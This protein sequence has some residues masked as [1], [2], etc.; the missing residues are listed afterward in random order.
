MTSIT[1]LW[2]IQNS[3]NLVNNEIKSNAEFNPQVAAL[4][5][6][7][8]F[9][10]GKM[11]IEAYPLTQ[12]QSGQPRNYDD[13]IAETEFR[14]ERENVMEQQNSLDSKPQA[15]VGFKLDFDIKEKLMKYMNALINDLDKAVQGELDELTLNKL[16][17]Q[18]TTFSF[19]YNENVSDIS[20][21]AEF[22]PNFHAQV[23]KIERLFLKIRKELFDYYQVG[24]DYDDSKIKIRRDNVDYILRIVDNILY[25]TKQMLDNKNTSQY[26]SENPVS[27]EPTPEMEYTPVVYEDGEIPIDKLPEFIDIL[28]S[29]IDD[30]DMSES[31]VLDQLKLLLNFLSNESQKISLEKIETLSGRS[32]A[33]AFKSYLNEFMEYVLGREAYERVKEEFDNDFNKASFIILDREATKI[34]EKYPEMMKNDED[35]ESD[36]A[37]LLDKIYNILDKVL[38]FDDREKLRKATTE[39]EIISYINKYMRN[40]YPDMVYNLIKD[41]DKKRRLNTYL[42]TLDN[43]SEYVPDDGTE[44]PGTGDRDEDGK[45]GMDDAE[46]D[47]GDRT[48]ATV[49]DAHETGITPAA[50]EYTT[51]PRPATAARPATAMTSRSERKGLIDIIDP[52]PR[53]SLTPGGKRLDYSKEGEEKYDEIKPTFKARK[54]SKGFFMPQTITLNENARTKGFNIVKKYNETVAKLLNEVSIKIPKFQPFKIKDLEEGIKTTNKYSTVFRDRSKNKT[55]NQDTQIVS[56]IT[57]TDIDKLYERLKDAG[58]ERNDKDLVLRALYINYWF[59]FTD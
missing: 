28:K 5:Y 34:M 56:L 22:L 3:F 43:L 4:R 41:M 10:T 35:E 21:D 23:I 54:D 15:Y 36:E 26:L 27:L 46:A 42:R 39:D 37:D 53:S 24:F 19:V 18:F 29:E 31:A 1:E 45:M 51:P 50:T 58:M 59:N 6:A 12:A 44:V 48:L 55:V 9:S 47:F 52:A 11:K 57:E 13:V 30:L 40:Y 8:T 33:V 2:R 14:I 20:R 38:N 25:M 32:Y 17:Q 7:D 49:E 16:S